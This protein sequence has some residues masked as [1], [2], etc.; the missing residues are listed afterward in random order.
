M[1]IILM[2]F[3][4]FLFVLTLD[5]SRRRGMTIRS[6]VVRYV[7]SDQKLQTKIYHIFVKLEF[8]HKTS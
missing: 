2:S 5:S 7:K 6:S 4:D 3:K 1:K 8:L